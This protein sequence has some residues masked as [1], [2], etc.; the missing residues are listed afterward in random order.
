M[1][2]YDFGHTIINGKH[3]Y[4]DTRYIRGVKGVVA[5]ILIRASHCD[6]SEF[7]H[8]VCR[9]SFKRTCKRHSASHRESVKI[10]VDMN[11]VN[12]SFSYGNYIR[13]Q[14]VV[15]LNVGEWNKKGFNIIKGECSYVRDMESKDPL[16]N[17][18]QV[19]Q[20]KRVVSKPSQLEAR[21]TQLEQAVRKAHEILL[22]EMDNGRTPV[23]LRGVGLG[24]FEDVIAGINGE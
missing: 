21:N 12:S 16:F 13:N 9:S 18:Y 11:I 1:N 15:Y 22:H 5:E 14:P 6:N 17:N 2:R 7:G 20:M 19:V 23:M 4:V 24:Y 8:F 10:L 3:V